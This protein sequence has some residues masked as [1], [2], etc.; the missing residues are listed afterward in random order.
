MK[1]DHAGKPQAQAQKLAALTSV[2]GVLDINSS[3][4]SEGPATF[5]EVFNSQGAFYYDPS[6]PS[7][8]LDQP[9]NP[10]PAAP[11]TPCIGFVPALNK[12]GAATTDD[13]RI[14]VP[15][16]SNDIN[17]GAV[18]DTTK[19]FS[20]VI[21]YFPDNYFV[22]DEFGNKIPMPKYLVTIS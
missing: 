13:L 18:V 6:V 19:T 8:R 1:P 17:A 16:P 7:Y 3:A 20:A 11:G 10:S 9:T 15:V 14:Y 4:Y 12:N 2:M 5:V 22:T 21:T